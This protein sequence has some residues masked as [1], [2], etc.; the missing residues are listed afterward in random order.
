[1]V[2][3]RI[4]SG[5]ARRLGIVGTVVGWG[6]INTRILPALLPIRESI[7]SPIHPS[8]HPSIS[9]YHVP[10][11]PLPP[12]HNPRLP[13]LAPLSPHRNRTPLSAILH[14]AHPIS[15]PQV[16]HCSKHPPSASLPP[17]QLSAIPLRPPRCHPRRPQPAE[18]PTCA[19]VF[20]QHSTS[21]P[22]Y[23]GSF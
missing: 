20:A 4:S 11:A 2:G 10:H 18:L 15:T 14:P 9:P 7:S 6:H 3:R 23:R 17:K 5:R 13:Q 19:R 21:L 1:M 12:P 16:Y 22:Y 8:I